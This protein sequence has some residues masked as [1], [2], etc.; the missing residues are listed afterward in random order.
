MVL[1]IGAGYIG[2][3]VASR[4]ATSSLLVLTTKTQKRAEE[5]SKS[6][7]FVHC[8]DVDNLEMLEEL[9]QDQDSIIITVAAHSKELYED[10]YLKC[11][12]HLREILSRNSSVKQII[13]TSSSSVYGEC[14]GQRV[15]ENTPTSPLNPSAE[16]LKQTEEVFLRMDL[17]D[18]PVC[19]FR[20]SE[21]YGP[22]RG[23]SERVNYY[24]GKKA[25]GSGNQ[26][27]NMIHQEDAARAICY[28]LQHHLRGIYNLCDDNHMPRKEL[29]DEIAKRFDLPFVQWDLSLTSIHQGSKIVS[30]DKIKKT[31]FSFLYPHRQFL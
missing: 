6:Y 27:T 16:I 14:E 5:L 12:Q 15:D 10:T 22:G 24:A 11:A 29:Y 13:Y 28:A 7:P 23:I 17:P 3:A 20:L 19:I 25:P 18:R 8:F 26:P 21:I 30:N 9:V 31:G 2:E 1:I 4:L